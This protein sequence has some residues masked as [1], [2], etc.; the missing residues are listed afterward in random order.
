MG[1]GPCGTAMPASSRGAPT[2]P[3]LS[4]LGARFRARS[5]H[6]VGQGRFTCTPPPCLELPA[7]RLSSA[8]RG[9]SR[10]AVN[11]P[12]EIGL[13]STARTPSPAPVIPDLMP[14]LRLPVHFHCPFRL[15]AS[16]SSVNIVSGKGGKRATKQTAAIGDWDIPHPPVR[17]PR[18][19]RLG[20]H[21][22]PV[23]FTSASQRRF[24]VAEAADKCPPSGSALDLERVPRSPDHLDLKI[25]RGAQP[26]RLFSQVPATKA[27]SGVH[28]MSGTNGRA[29]PRIRH[30]FADG[31]MAAM[32]SWVALL[33]TTRAPEATLDGS[34]PPNSS[35]PLISGR[36]ICPA[37]RDPP[38]RSCPGWVRRRT[39]TKLDGRRIRW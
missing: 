20:P 31:P 13:L 37:R 15:L 38:D 30:V 34:V 22:S 11:G 6:R 28:F 21:H 1:T 4:R 26:D 3:C 17:F 10:A 16:P 24:A 23:L 18:T 27:D 35:G 5:K 19:A 2:A 14:T 32:A 8:R 25:A 12:P 7:I 9:R 39:L 33:A 36:A 29:R